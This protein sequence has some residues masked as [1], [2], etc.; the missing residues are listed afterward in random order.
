MSKVKAP[1]LPSTEVWYE[2]KEYAKVEG[3]RK[4]RLLT[5][6]SDPMVY[7]WAM[8]WLFKT[9]EEARKAKK[10]HAP[11]EEWV[12]VKVTMEPVRSLRRDCLSA[13]H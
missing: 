11:D 13:A 10:E 12:L 1:P 3:E 2:W 6:W 5:P 8:D 7:E 4:R 9:P